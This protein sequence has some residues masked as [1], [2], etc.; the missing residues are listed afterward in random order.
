MKGL[1]LVR[2]VPILC[3]QTAELAGYTTRILI[4]EEAK[5]VKEEEADSWEHRVSL[6]RSSP[7]V[8]ESGLVYIYM[9]FLTL[10]ASERGSEPMQK[11]GM[12]SL[13][14][15]SVKHPPQGPGF[16]SDLGHL[17]H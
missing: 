14:S 5:R 4:L 1:P 9:C 11:Q 7:G 6:G 15:S 3:M 10:R 8:G 17:S 16:G 13:G 12:G 2:C